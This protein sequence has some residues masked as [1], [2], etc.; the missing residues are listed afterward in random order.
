M[1]PILARKLV[2]HY[3]ESKEGAM[4]AMMT[5]L[6]ETG[7]W[8][9][10]DIKNK[11]CERLLPVKKEIQVKSSADLPQLDFLY[12][13]RQV[14]IT[15]CTQT[16]HEILQKIINKYTPPEFAEKIHR[17]LTIPLREYL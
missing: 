11:A 14:H 7:F 5:L 2:D 9:W 1:C 15:Q 17:P 10:T 3:C 13:K 12:K 4:D 8:A 16:L 6:C